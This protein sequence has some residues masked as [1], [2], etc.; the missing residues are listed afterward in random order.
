VRDFRIGT[1]S[2]VLFEE[3]SIFMKVI[4][5]G[6]G[7]T[8]TTSLKVALE[9][10]GYGPCYHMTEAFEHPEHAPL[11][12]AATRG[13]PVD[14]KKL[15][16]G[17]Q[18]TV[19]WPGAAFYKE[20]MQEYPDAKVLLSVRDPDKWYESATN[21]IYVYATV[22]IPNPAPGPEIVNS[23]IWERTFGGNFEDRPYAIEVFK[24]HN[25]EV[26]EHVPPEQLL[27]YRV[28]EGWGPLCEFLGVDAPK[29]KPFPR[30]NDSEAFGQM[31]Q[32]Y[33][34]GLGA[35]ALNDKPFL[36]APEEVLW[37]EQVQLATREIALVIPPGELFILVDEDNWLI[38]ASAGRRAI[39]FLERDGRYWGPPPDDEIAIR[40]LKRLRQ[41]GASFMVFGWPA[42]WWLDYYAGLRSYLRSRFR[43]LLEN[44][45]IVVFDLRGEMAAGEGS[46]ELTWAMD[47]SAGTGRGKR[48]GEAPEQSI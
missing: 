27:V 42:F 34:E 37:H 31:V 7:R 6:F 26:K 10:L 44:E 30:L 33:L 22:D 28:Q 38:S 32:P 2:G 19:D 4:G 11:W 12:E 3:G 15:F 13:E 39:P 47:A 5:A 23:L 29:N 1:T 9:E 25:E 14:W 48:G 24:R 36:R 17:Y 35:E 21:T 45:R 43:C 46:Q 41:S 16:S 8:G 20:L 40:E 18:A